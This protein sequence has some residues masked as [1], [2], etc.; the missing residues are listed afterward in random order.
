MV[1][2]AREESA[3]AD[4]GDERLDARMALTLS[5]LGTRPNLSIPAA[6]GG[7]AEMAGAYRFFDNPKVTF[8]KVLAPHL[9]RTV[10]RLKDQPV[11]LLV[12]DTT[13]IDLTRPEQVIEGAGTLD[14]VRVGVLLHALQAFSPNGTPLGTVWAQVRNRSDGVKHVGKK[15]RSARAAMP[16]EQKESVRW[17]TGLREARAVAERLP[18]VRCVCVADSEADIYELL[19]EPRGQAPLHFLIRAAQDRAVRE[20][21]PGGPASLRQQ[22]LATPV[23]Y[24]AELRI[25]GRKAL[26][27]QEHR[28]RRSPRQSRQACVQVRA[29]TLTLRPPWRADRKLAPVEVNVVLAHESHPPVGEEA[30]EWILVTSLPIATAAQVRTI[31]EYYCVRWGIELLF[32]MLKSGCRIEQRR[33]EHVDRI[34]PCLAMY[35]IVAWRTLFVCHLGRT[36]PELDCQAIFE[37]CEWK[38]VWT[39][40]HGQQ[41]PKE[42]PSLSQMVHLIARLGGYVE[43]PKSEPGAQTI[44]IGLQRMHD[45][46]WAWENFGPGSKVRDGQDV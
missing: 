7:R 29:L 34:L 14:G 19:A 24:E 41:P 32:R 22:V 39:A 18:G 16:L 43:R 40:V 46:A 17:L 20:A 9:T 44:W 45:L 42:R 37:A 25:R 21:D 23:L 2:W 31:V 5:A 28:R 13:E 26:T 1:P 10:E 15:K 33:F 27:A 8:D 36:C 11:V 38:A 6:C 12:Q 30:I 35:L 3:G 4:F